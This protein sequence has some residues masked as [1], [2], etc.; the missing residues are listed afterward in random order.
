MHNEFCLGKIK[1]TIACL[2]LLVM[3]VY[4]VDIL[5]P[6]VFGDFRTSCTVNTNFHRIMRLGLRK[7]C[8]HVAFDLCLRSIES[9]SLDQ[10]RL[11]I[12]LSLTITELRLVLPISSLSPVSSLF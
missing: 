10:Y 6:S 3:L 12:K 1:F 8:C 2:I 7:T 4:V 9:Y 11:S 5:F